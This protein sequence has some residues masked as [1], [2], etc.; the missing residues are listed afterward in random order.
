MLNSRSVLFNVDRNPFL[1]WILKTT[2]YAQF[3]AGENK[4]EVQRFIK[5]IEAVG[6]NGVCLEYAMEV[7]ED[8]NAQEANDLDK[9][10]SW[11][12]GVME[13]IDMSKEGSFLAFK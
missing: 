8:D 5:D 10:T 6:Y 2:F 7:L 9:I 13:T 4:A 1:R 11:K 12:E 3:C